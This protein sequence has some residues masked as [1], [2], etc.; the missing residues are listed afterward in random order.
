MAV[1]HTP[2]ERSDPGHLGGFG[3]VIIPSLNF[4]FLMCQDG[5]HNNKNDDDDDDMAAFGELNEKLPKK[6]SV[7]INVDI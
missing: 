5:W 2:I 6:K 3:Q 7:Q 4:N 1:C